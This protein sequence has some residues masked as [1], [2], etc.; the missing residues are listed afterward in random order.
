MEP[1]LEKLGG[2]GERERREGGGRER[3]KGGG[4]AME[5]DIH[6]HLVTQGCMPLCS[7]VPRPRP[8]TAQPGNEAS[9]CA[10][11]ID[12]SFISKPQFKRSGKLRAPPS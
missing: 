11:Y 2:G 3:E 4:E 8:L 1:D 9:P 6:V 10:S 5:G 7:L 12:T